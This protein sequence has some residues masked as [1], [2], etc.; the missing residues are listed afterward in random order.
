MTTEHDWLV[1]VDRLDWPALSL[2]QR[3][4]AIADELMKGQ[5]SEMFCRM[6]AGMIH[7]KGKNSTQHVFCLMHKNVGRPTIDDRRAIAM[8]RLRDIDGLS[9]DAAAAEM[10]ARFGRKGTSPARCA[11]Y[12]DRGRE[13]ASLD[14]LFAEHIAQPKAQSLK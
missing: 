7:P 3:A 4:A 11:A 2:E 9:F 6:L 13:L 12:L 1:L 14:R 5:P 10:Q 8:A